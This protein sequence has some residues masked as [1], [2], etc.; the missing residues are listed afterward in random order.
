[1]SVRI[2]VI[3]PCYN[4]GQFLHDAISGIADSNVKD[5]E[6]IVINDGS[7]EAQT[8]AVLEHL[9]APGLQIIHQ[10]NKGLASA[11]N[12][13]LA[14]AKG[15]FVLPLDAD[16]KIRPA[17]FREGLAIMDGNPDVA[18]VYGMAEYFDGRSGPWNPG[19]FNLQKLMISN[20]I[21]ACALI[22]KSVLDKVGWYD[23][24]MKFMG[25][26][27]WDRWLAI[28][29]AGYRF[30][31]LNMVCFDYRVTSGSMIKDLY[32]KYEKP[33]H[34]ENYVHSK[35]QHQ[36]GH[37]WI[38]NYF[39]TR[40]KK[41]PLLFMVKLIIASWFPSYYQQLLRKNKIRNGI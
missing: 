36:M 29:F 32:G 26:E 37:H 39:T 2:S 24:N 25:W 16:N 7:T 30:H 3:I 22:R 14:L 31:Y 11:R 8:L 17:Y 15:E 13:G 19:D 27:D 20:Y 40:F 38:M 21:D 4:Q 33:N 9:Q 41:N 23:E 5:V 35:Y 6:I 28:S 1:M 12:A 18:V 34:L 10:N